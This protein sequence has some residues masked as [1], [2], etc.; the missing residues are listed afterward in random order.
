MTIYSLEGSPNAKKGVLL[1]DEEEYKK[2]LYFEGKRKR[3]AWEP[4]SAS[5]VGN[6]S[7][8]IGDF[9][10]FAPGILVCNEKALSILRRNCEVEIEALDM[11][12]KGEHYWMINVI[13]VID[14]F[15][16]DRAVYRK[17]PFED[18]IVE[19]NKYSFEAS[20]LSNTFLFKVPQ[21]VRTH[22][23]CTSRFRSLYDSEG[24]TGLEFLVINEGARS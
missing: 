19:V 9:I 22:V 14:C 24:L 3:S 1:S 8:D 21:L 15:D 5:I 16:E 2:L 20:R 7:G 18:T 6:N 12:V 10:P 13:N 23:F 17:S 11:Q 4:V